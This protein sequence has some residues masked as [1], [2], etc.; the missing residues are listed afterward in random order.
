MKPEEFDADTLGKLSE[1]FAQG[2]TMGDVMGYDDRDYAAVYALGHQL[3]TQE[4]YE[5]AMRAFGFLA[6]HDHLEPKYMMAYASALQMMK[7]YAEALTYYSSASL[8]DLTDPVPTFH[9]AECMIA[10]GHGMDARAALNMVIRDCAD[11]PEYAELRTRAHLL[12]ELIDDNAS[13][14]GSSES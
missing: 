8:F 7:R 11:R 1:M 6:L 13:D 3:Y 5:D 14:H 4:R 12:L 10:L 2:L 9:S